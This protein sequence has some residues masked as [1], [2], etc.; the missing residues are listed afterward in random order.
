MIELWKPLSQKRA[1]RSVAKDVLELVPFGTE[2]AQNDLQ[3]GHTLTAIAA[4]VVHQHDC[5]RE[6][7]REH[8]AMQPIDLAAIL[9]STVTNFLPVTEERGLTLSARSD[10][11][12]EIHADPDRAA[13]VLRNLIA[14]ALW[15][16]PPRGNITVAAQAIDRTVDVTA[17][18]TGEGT[19]PEDKPHVF[20]R[21]YRADKARTH[22]DGGSGLGLAIAKSLIEAMGGQIGVESTPGR[23]SHF[24]FTLP[25]VA[26]P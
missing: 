23:G 10:R 22:H 13:Q 18:K 25:R 7:V 4:A 17:S 3:R 26:V 12:V 14:N 15:H 21:F 1:T 2:F 6:D 19:A 9:G 8:V 5:A 11:A 20:D 16:T 24:W